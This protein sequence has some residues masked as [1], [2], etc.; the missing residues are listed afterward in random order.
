MASVT[1]QGMLLAPGGRGLRYFTVATSPAAHIEDRMQTSPHRGLIN[2]TPQSIFLFIYLYFIIIMIL[3]FFLG[4]FNIFL[5]IWNVLIN[6]AFKYGN[7]F[8]DSM[9][10]KETVHT[11]GDESLNRTPSAKVTVTSVRVA[12]RNV[13]SIWNV[14]SE[15]R[16]NK[17]KMKFR[18]A[19]IGDTRPSLFHSD[20]TSGCPL[21]PSH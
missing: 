2:H 9:K 15:K 6:L 1:H 10:C 11:I 3:F 12:Q 19:G 4:I 18:A 13:T 7:H 8:N 14:V 20:P 21:T 16:I 17:T 5:Y